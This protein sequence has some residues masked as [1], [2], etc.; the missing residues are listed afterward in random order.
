MCFVGRLVALVP[1]AVFLCVLC[2][3]VWYVSSFRTVFILFCKICSCVSALRTV[4]NV[5]RMIFWH[6]SASRTVLNGFCTISC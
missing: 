1:C 4:F 6:F 5:F 2:L 3:N